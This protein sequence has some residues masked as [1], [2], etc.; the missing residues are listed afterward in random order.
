ML[1]FY[2]FKQ[3][4]YKTGILQLTYYHTPVR[5]GFTKPN[6]T[7]YLSAD[8][9][10]EINVYRS[11][12][13]TKNKV[14]DYAMANTWD[15]F[16]TITLD[17]QKIDRYN[18]TII[19]KKISKQF[20]NIK[21]KGVAPNLKYILVPEQHKDGAWH[22]HALISN[23]GNL[24]LNDSLRRVNGLPIYNI[25]NFTFGFTTCLKIYNN[26]GISQYITKYITKDLTKIAFGKKKYWVSRNLTI[27][28]IDKCLFT[29]DDLSFVLKNSNILNA[30]TKVSFVNN[31]IVTPSIEYY[32]V[33]RET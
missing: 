14:Y 3:K 10:K 21:S 24:R 18:Y 29:I 5:V 27:P 16:L 7:M 28:I 13:R 23:I 32:N 4:D 20:N 1:S 22:F 19:S 25:P 12:I 26:S 2:N 30:K 11:M 33:S 9:T 31:G 17:K 8:D 6:T 15:Y